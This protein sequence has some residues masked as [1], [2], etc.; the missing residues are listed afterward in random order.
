M[1]DGA[2]FQARPGAGRPGG[3]PTVTWSGMRRT[4]VALV[5]AT[6]GLSL[7][8]L[9]VQATKPSAGSTASIAAQAGAHNR[10]F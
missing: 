1:K 4:L 2:P 9:Q 5:I 8:P 6:L 7:L 3:K 10:F